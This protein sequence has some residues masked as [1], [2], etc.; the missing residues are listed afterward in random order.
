MPQF[1]DDKFILRG[2]YVNLRPL[3]IDD[4][5][6]TFRWR[7]GERAALLNQGAQTVEQ[8]ISWITSRP[9]NE[10][11]FII[12]TRA[13][14][15]IGMLSLSGID[16]ANRVGEPG[17]FLIGD[18][19]AAQGIPAAAEAMKLLYELAFDRLELRRI[20]GIVAS[21]N[22]RMIKWQ[23]YLGMV[24]EGC[25]RQHLFLNGKSQ[26]AILFGLLADEYRRVT[27]PRLESLIAA[28]RLPIAQSNLPE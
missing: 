4:A 9:T 5:E 15:P 1:L 24:R 13:D 21:N 25:L 3:R 14:K 8:Q 19:E 26:D 16:V 6:F 7:R 22:H 12:E 2:R 11:N 27:L 23:T 17:R 18:E 10:H 28:A 20:W